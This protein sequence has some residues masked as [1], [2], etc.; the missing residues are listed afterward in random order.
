[1]NF[2]SKEWFK[3]LN[4]MVNFPSNFAFYYNKK[5]N[6][7]QVSKVDSKAKV[8]NIRYKD[9]A[10]SPL[11]FHPK[12]TALIKVKTITSDKEYYEEIV[13]LQEQWGTSFTA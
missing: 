10:P 11:N 7:I 3:R 12:E 5:E 1:L 9:V 8:E 2:G 4:E 13:K 6:I